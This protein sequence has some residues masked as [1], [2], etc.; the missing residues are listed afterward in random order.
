MQK[1]ESAIFTIFSID[2][3][4]GGLVGTSDLDTWKEI[5][6]NSIVFLPMAGV[7]TPY[8]DSG[9]HPILRENGHYL[10][11]TGVIIEYGLYSAYDLYLNINYDEFIDYH[12]RW[13]NASS[14]RLVC[15]D[16][17]DPFQ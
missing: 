14:L 5:D 7:L 4:E 13:D 15:D 1:G 10:C 3:H 6:S 12:G 8:S 11:S 17:W 9:D 2:D 16:S